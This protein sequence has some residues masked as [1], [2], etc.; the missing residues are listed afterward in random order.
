MNDDT[1]KDTPTGAQVRAEIDA[2]RGAEIDD[3]P[4]ASP[5]ETGPEAG[6]GETTREQLKTARRQADRGD[7]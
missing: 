5:L 3:T 1:D 4:G 7:D 6:A 2:A